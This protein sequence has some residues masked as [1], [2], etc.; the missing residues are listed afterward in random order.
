MQIIK[1]TITSSDLS[2][3]SSSSSSS[4]AFGPFYLSFSYLTLQ[5]TPGIQGILCPRRKEEGDRGWG[6]KGVGCRR[7]DNA[8][9]S[10]S[11]GFNKSPSNTFHTHTHRY[12]HST[13]T[14]Q[15][16]EGAEL[17][18]ARQCGV[19]GRGEKKESK[20]TPP[21]PPP[22]SAPFQCFVGCQHVLSPLFSHRERRRKTLVFI[23][24]SSPVRASVTEFD[25]G[26]RGHLFGLAVIYY[27]PH[28]LPSTASCLAFYLNK[29]MPR[30]VWSMNCLFL[31]ALKYDSSLLQLGSY[32]CSFGHHSSWINNILLTWWDLGMRATFHVCTLLVFPRNEVV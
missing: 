4:W 14:S 28:L 7:G 21:P 16:T 22:P 2:F 30:L 27:Y 23:D 3:S 8:R 29:W 24:P 25:F 26:I 9:G 17:R 13:T 18:A 15:L 11:F 31:L 5:E 12:T 19:R 1:S 10:T 6:S 32:I 20:C